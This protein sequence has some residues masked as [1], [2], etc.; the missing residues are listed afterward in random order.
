MLHADP[1]LLRSSP[2]SQPTDEQQNHRD[3]HQEADPNMDVRWQVLRGK[4][5]GLGGS[6]AMFWHLFGGQGA[7]D[8]F[9]LDRWGNLHIPPACVLTLP[10]DGTESNE[11]RTKHR[12]PFL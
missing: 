4:L 5:E 2:A 3:T 1:R 11:G 8:T 6:E 7:E 9:W 12:H 10:F